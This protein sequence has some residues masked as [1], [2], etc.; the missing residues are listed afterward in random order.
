MTT[1]TPVELTRVPR[2]TEAI[3]IINMLQEHDI[4]AEMIGELTS[5]LRAE[6]PGEV[7]ILV[8]QQDLTQAQKIL[9]EYYNKK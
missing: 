3:L 7:R 8:H 5:G 1:P 6:A 9:D 4:Y 2:E